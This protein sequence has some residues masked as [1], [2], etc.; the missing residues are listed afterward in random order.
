MATVQSQLR[1]NDGMSGVLRSV[2]SAL[3]ICLTSFERLQAASGQTMDIESM[4]SARVALSDA[5]ALVE[6]MERNYRDVEDQQSRV[7]SQQN[8]VNRSIRAGSSAVDGLIGRI[9]GMVAAYA[10]VQGIGRLLT[11]SDNIA[12]TQARLDLIVGTENVSMAQQQIMDMANR[13]RAGFQSTADAVTKMGINAG[14]SFSGFEEIVRFTE[15]MNKNFV[16]GGASIQEQTSAMY[17]LTQAMSAGKLQGDEFRSIVENAP[18]LA[19][20]ITDYMRNAG[21]S[22]TLKEWSADGLLTADV[23]KNA[24]FSASDEI[25]A[26][27]EAM[28]TTWEQVWTQFEN[29]ATDAMAP[30]LEKLSELANSDRVKDLMVD[31]GGAL[32]DVADIAVVVL[33]GIVDV[34][35]YI[36]SHQSDIVTLI[37]GITGA[38]IAWHAAQLALN[39]AVLSNPYIALVVGTGF[40]LGSVVVTVMS[41]ELVGSPAERLMRMAPPEPINPLL[42]ET[43]TNAVEN[44]TTVPMEIIRIFENM[45]DIQGSGETK[46]SN[47]ALMEQF[48]ADTWGSLTTSVETEDPVAAMQASIAATA[49]E[50]MGAASTALY[51]ADAYNRLYQSGDRSSAA[52]AQMG[53][54]VGEVNSLI[55]NLNAQFDA[56]T[57]AIYGIEGSLY[58]AA[59]AFYRYAEAQAFAAAYKTELQNAAQAWIQ[60]D[61]V[62]RD[63]QARFASVN[64]ADY[65][66]I[67]LRSTSLFDATQNRDTIRNDMQYLMDGWAENQ[68]I[69]NSF[70][71]V[72][73]QETAANTRRMANSLDISNEDLKYLREIA[74]REA[75][76]RFTTAEIKVDMTGM[77]NRIDS[78]LDVDGIITRFV[79]GVTEAVASDMEAAS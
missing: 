79:D 78:D 30:V 52:I 4:T 74:E 33:E 48:I 43:V 8:D 15:L 2:T 7:E 54:V 6:Q 61:M 73:D 46:Y 51:L 24:L 47:P 31:I 12:G 28:P 35:D 10:S 36:R 29:T 32:V 64:G 72:Y 22:G 13:T 58:A 16:I 37:G 3:D 38:I 44:G 42:T 65:M 75:V 55:P 21:V 23:I 60:A 5:N 57:G 27:F 56:T 69:V 71:S 11:L 70:G 25:N 26:R 59:D 34:F 19:N 1:L 39:G 77:T 18:L 68:A 45:P 76:N 50:S 20:A 40:A 53:A 41:G 62:V 49:A 9:G 17:Q 66:D 14:K 63:E 67:L